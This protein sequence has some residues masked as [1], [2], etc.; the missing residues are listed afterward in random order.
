MKLSKRH[1]LHKLYLPFKTELSSRILRWLEWKYYELKWLALY[2]NKD[3]FESISIETNTFCQLHCP[4]CPNS[5]NDRGEKKNEIRLSTGIIINLIDELKSIGYKGRIGL[6]RF[7]EPLT[8]ER[9]VSIVKI[10][11]KALPKNI[12]S[13]AT[14]GLMLTEK[15]FLEL[16]DAGVTEFYVT[17]YGKSLDK[18]LEL[19]EKYGSILHR[20]LTEDD[21]LYNR[22]GLVTVKKSFGMRG[23]QSGY[24]RAVQVDPSGNIVYCYN[25]YF[26]D[27]KMGNLNES[28][29]LDIWKC[30]KY[31]FVRKQ[32][33]KQ[34][35]NHSKLC[36]KCE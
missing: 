28:S 2:G 12:I 34:N 29:F 21:P 22:G 15:L 36:T 10:I 6:S 18:V 17:E 3:F 1:L 33:R 8:D 31:K 32:L 16:K 30:D 11:R 14:N 26:S 13:I 23:C 9:L 5:N 24:S 35:Y 25:D 19:K 7:N 27:G 4:F 20:R